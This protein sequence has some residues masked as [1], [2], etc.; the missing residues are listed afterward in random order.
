MHAHWKHSAKE[1]HMKV[2][3]LIDIEE[4]SDRMHFAAVDLVGV[5][6]TRLRAEIELAGCD[7][8]HDMEE[9]YCGHNV[10]ICEMEVLE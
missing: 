8:C 6:T 10:L 4:T 9:E 3:V 2:F 5:F 7:A 1:P